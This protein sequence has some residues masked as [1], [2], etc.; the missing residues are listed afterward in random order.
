MYI[1]EVHDLADEILKTVRES[2][3]G[4]SKKDIIKQLFMDDPE[5]LK[6]AFEIA[7]EENEILA[8]TLDDGEEGYRLNP[9]FDEYE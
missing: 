3:E 7:T 4:I 1:A 5:Y 2:P 6:E 8:I 9:E